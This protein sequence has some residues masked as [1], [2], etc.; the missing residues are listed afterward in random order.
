MSNQE[1]YYEDCSD[2]D[3]DWLLNQNSVQQDNNCTL[4]IKPHNIESWL[5][6]CKLLQEHFISLQ[7]LPEYDSD[8]AHGEEMKTSKFIKFLNKKRNGY[9]H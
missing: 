8:W 3:Y 7:K 1:D 4:P 9:N 6:I 2:E 5:N